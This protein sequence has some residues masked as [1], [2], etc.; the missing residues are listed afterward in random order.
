MNIFSLPTD[1]I[2]DQLKAVIRDIQNI[3]G[4]QACDFILIGATARDL[5]LDGQYNLGV[6][7]KTLDLDFAIYVPEWGT[8]QNMLDKL[9]QSGLF[10]ATKV[11]HKLIYKEVCEIDIVPFGE[12]QNEEGEYDWPPDFIRSMN[13]AG[14][15]EV[16]EETIKFKLEEDDLIFSV[17]PIHAIYFMKIYAWNDR[18]Y[19]DDKDGKDQGFI[20]ANYIEL[21]YEVLYD[22][23]E[24]IVNNE[25][26]DIITSC[27][28]ILGRD[29]AQLLKNNP[30]ALQKTIFIIKK[31]LEDNDNSYLARSMAAGGG[32]EYKKAYRALEELLKGIR[33]IL[34][35]GD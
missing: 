30:K 1:K 20:L 16:R 12:I 27:A 11:T 26:W 10:T 9:V 3:L 2:P 5:I 7:P 29:I 35:I 33:D 8:Y 17:A 23:H 22:E 15:M 18:K 14:F 4:D 21:K 19:R 13:V 34:R 32:F 25:D 28:R 31:E 24:D 6:G